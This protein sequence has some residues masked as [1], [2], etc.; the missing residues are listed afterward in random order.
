MNKL[1]PRT[2]NIVFQKLEYP[3]SARACRFV[4]D[5]TLCLYQRAVNWIE[6]TCCTCRDLLYKSLETLG[7][8][9]WSVIWVSQGK[10]SA[11]SSSS[12]R[13]GKCVHSTKIGLN[14]SSV[15]NKSFLWKG[16]TP[17]AASILGPPS[18]SFFHQRVFTIEI[19][20]SA[21]FDIQPTLLCECG[22][23]SFI[24]HVPELE[25]LVAKRFHVLFSAKETL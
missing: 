19:S 17:V 16:I 9:K 5:D 3:T 8:R 18:R 10:T 12:S 7:L 15:R 6:R 1:A 14:L 4:F 2:K 11:L 24:P 20:S 13:L 22:V 21:F 23:D 25:H